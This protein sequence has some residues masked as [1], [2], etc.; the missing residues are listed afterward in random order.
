VSPYWVGLGLSLVIFGAGLVFVARKWGTAEGE[1]VVHLPLGLKVEKVSHAVF[2]LL[3]GVVGGGL[4]IWQ[5]AQERE[6]RRN[7]TVAL[8]EV[9]TLDNLPSP[10]TKDDLKNQKRL[11]GW[12]APFLLSF[13]DK[14][15]IVVNA[16]SDEGVSEGD[17][18]ATVSNRERATGLP[19]YKVGNLQ[20]ELTAILKVARVYP[21]SSVSQLNSYAYGAHLSTLPGGNL[22]DIN[23]TQLRDAL[24]PVAPGQP[25][26][27]IPRNESAARD[28]LEDQW[29]RAAEDGLSG[30][31]SRFLDK[32]AIRS[33]NEFLLDYPDGFF[34]SEVMFDKGYAL[35]RIE[36]LKAALATFEEFLDRYPFHYSADCRFSR[37]RDHVRVGSLRN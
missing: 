31:R 14:V 9:S 37:T 32:E 12:Y 21:E 13:Y 22:L 1:A 20:D 18:F 5:L 15:G 36:S 28:S 11:F 8:F 35:F 2:I 33:A 6:A 25:V 19:V 24:S 4:C 30:A 26:A 3:I 34:A 27:S 23:P 16:G 29:D 7:T 10:P 17:Y